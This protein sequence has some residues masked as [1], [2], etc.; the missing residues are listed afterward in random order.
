MLKD[1]FVSDFEE[2]QLDLNHLKIG[3]GNR[4]LSMYFE[5]HLVSGGVTRGPKESQ[6]GDPSLGVETRVDLR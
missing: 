6:V 4:F 2:V 3:S 5:C 1:W